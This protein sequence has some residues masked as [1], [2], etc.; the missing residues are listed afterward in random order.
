[1]RMLT[2]LLACGA[3]AAIVA[4]GAGP[5]LADPPDGVKPS[6]TS[7]VGVGS[8]T[9]EYLYDQLALDYDSAHK[10]DAQ[11]YSWDATNPTT[12]ATGDTIVT[13]SG[14]S[15]IAR[16]DG[17]G[18]GLKAFEANTADGSGYCIDYARSARAR[19]ASDP[20]CTTGGICFVALAGDAVTYATR[21][22]AAG[23]TDAPAD[24]STSQLAGIYECKTTNWSKVGGKNAT[25]KPY[26]PVSGSAIA[27]D[28][29]TALGGGVTPI[30]PGNCVQSTV[31]QNEGIDP[32]LNSA[33]AIVP[34]SVAKFLAQVYHSASCLNSSCTAVNGAICKPTGKQNKFGCNESGVLTLNEIDKK[35]PS[36]KWP[37]PKPGKGVNPVINGKFVSLFLVPIYTVVRDA[38]TPDSI[39]AYL[40]PLFAA[41]GASTPGWICTATTAHTDIVDYG[42]LISPECGTAS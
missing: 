11:I 40:E 15:G 9:S 21:S 14:C 22:S 37:L 6:A 26:L 31:Q 27:T 28:F 33:Q 18:Q 13:K 1:M 38:S 12:G 7:I 4:M 19:E 34:Y 36:N 30:Q 10:K 41:S 16:P 24:L 17:T 2:K 20:Q 32:S 5:A 23:G 25:I 8:D 42:F 29:L 39:P 3:G 35:A